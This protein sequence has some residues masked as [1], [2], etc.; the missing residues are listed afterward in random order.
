MKPLSRPARRRGLT[1]VEVVVSIALIGTLLSGVVM[2]MARHRHQLALAD[3]K[4]E[5]IE[6]ADDLLKQW[7]GRPPYPASGKIGEKNKMAWKTTRITQTANELPKG[8]G[9]V[10]LEVRHPSGTAAE[11]PLAQVDVLVDLPLAPDR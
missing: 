2:A 3:Q 4:I 7:E 5:A 10:R 6:A 11:K 1:L 8:V 9:I